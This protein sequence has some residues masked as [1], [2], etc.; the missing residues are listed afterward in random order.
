ML[1]KYAVRFILAGQARTYVLQDIGSVDAISTALDLLEIDIPQINLVA[2]L[3]VVAKEWTSGGSCLADE[4]IG[5]VLDTTR[6]LHAVKAE[7]DERVAA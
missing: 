7:A 6:G 5:P 2:G 4:G 1:K 3:S